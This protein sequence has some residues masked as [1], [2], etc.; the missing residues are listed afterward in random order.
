MRGFNNVS[1]LLSEASSID[2]TVYFLKL[3]LNCISCLICMKTSL[4][5]LG[6][7]GYHHQ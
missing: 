1:Q 6:C 3:I 2:Y 7:R 5:H 4:V